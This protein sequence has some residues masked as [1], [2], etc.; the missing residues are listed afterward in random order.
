MQQLLLDLRGCSWAVIEEGSSFDSADLPEPVFEWRFSVLLAL[1]CIFSPRTLQKHKALCKSVSFID[2]WLCDRSV[3]IFSLCLGMLRL[4]QPLLCCSHAAEPRSEQAS[5]WSSLSD[6]D[7]AVTA[8]LPCACIQYQPQDA[9][10]F[11]LF[12]FGLKLRA[13]G[14][15]PDLL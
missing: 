11:L 2:S 9:Y 12:A 3:S 5:C 10:P 15:L 6:G 13:D 1:Q 8:S 7:P 14:R 4:C